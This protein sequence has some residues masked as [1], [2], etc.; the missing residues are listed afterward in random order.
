LPNRPFTIDQLRERAEASVRE[1]G[2]G[3]DTVAFP[4]LLERLQYIGGDY[5]DPRTFVRLRDAL[6][7]ATRPLH[8]LAI[9]PSLFPTVVEA[10]GHSGCAE[11]ARVIVEKPFGHSVQT[12]RDLNRTMHSVFPESAIYRI[13]HY[14]GKDTVENL[15]IFRFANTFLEPIWNRNYVRSVQITMAEDFG[16]AGAASSTTRPVRSATWCRTT[17][18]RSWPSWR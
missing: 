11:N 15:L 4:K 2:G 13:D 9:P 17:C 8:Y 6:N 5:Q 7:G 16:V 18:S 14:L 12:A 10:L 1:Y 3:V